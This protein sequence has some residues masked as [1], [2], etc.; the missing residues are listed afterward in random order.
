MQAGRK[1]A[2]PHPG[3]PGASCRHCRNCGEVYWVWKGK[4][5]KLCSECAWARQVSNDAL[6]ARPST[7]HE[8]RTLVGQ[9]RYV[10]R[11]AEALGLDLSE[12]S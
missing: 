12:L 11:R 8:K 5:Q 3:Q 9:Y 2:E 1:A 10:L 7:E 4:S 6:T